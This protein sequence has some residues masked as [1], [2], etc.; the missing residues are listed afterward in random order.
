MFLRIKDSELL[1]ELNGL[2]IQGLLDHKVLERKD[3]SHI[4]LNNGR[5]EQSTLHLTLVNSTLGMK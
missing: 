3:L 4:T 5:Y 2:L 1:K